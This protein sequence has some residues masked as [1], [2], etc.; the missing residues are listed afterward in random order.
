MPRKNTTNA[1]ALVKEKQAVLDDS[2]VAL[3]TGVKLV[4][5]VAEQ[6]WLDYTSTRLPEDWLNAE[7]R[8]IARICNIESRLAKE[9]E[10]L[11]EMDTCLVDRF[12]KVYANPLISV[13][14]TLA[15][16][17]ASLITKVDLLGTGGRKSG[18]KTGQAKRVSAARKKESGTG[19]NVTSL[20]AG[21]G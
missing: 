15:S 10:L 5:E 3:P 1:Q 20:L 17:Q 4:D 11:L 8:I 6:S 19:N 14:N 12:G 18:T 21:R 7:L 2:V 16:Q 9:N 13:I